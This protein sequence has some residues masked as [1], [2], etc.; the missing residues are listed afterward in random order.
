MGRSIAIAA[1]LIGSSYL[2]I[3]YNIPTRAAEDPVGP[4][5]YPMLLG[6]AML[7]ISMMLW[8]EAQRAVPVAAAPVDPL[9]QRRQRLG[10]LGAAAA[11]VAYALTL[12]SVGYLLT[13]FLLMLGVTSAFHRGKLATNLAVSLGTATFLYVGLKRFLGVPLPSGILS[14]L[15]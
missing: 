1:F 5:M 15:G 8:L 6:G 11:A 10:I 13:T 14:F 12:E 9:L 4:R 2:A 7:L 3:A